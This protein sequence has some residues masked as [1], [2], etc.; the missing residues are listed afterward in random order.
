MYNK[1]PWSRQELS[2]LVLHLT[3]REL[4]VAMRR[5]LS[6]VERKVERIKLVLAYEA[7]V[8]DLGSLSSVK[9]LTIRR[10]ARRGN[11]RRARDDVRWFIK[12]YGLKHGMFRPHDEFKG[13]LPTITKRGRAHE[14]R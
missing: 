12:F 7:G 2:N 4:A 11:P 10:W 8:L 14:A 9:Q 1:L 3:E 5:T 6:S 13:L